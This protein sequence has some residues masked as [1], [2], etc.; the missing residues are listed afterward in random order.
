MIFET[1]NGQQML[2]FLKRTLTDEVI[3]LNSNLK[4]A[5]QYQVAINSSSVALSFHAELNDYYICS[6]IRIDDEEIVTYHVSIGG[7]PDGISGF[8]RLGNIFY[9]RDR[10]LIIL[11]VEVMGDDVK[12]RQIFFEIDDSKLMDF[13]KN[14]I[15]MNIVKSDQ[16][17]DK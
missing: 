4:P 3:I 11:E 17:S 5:R 15:A 12:P 14:K 10:G 16:E 13:A 9:C 8:R 2:S 1:I 7:I 6:A